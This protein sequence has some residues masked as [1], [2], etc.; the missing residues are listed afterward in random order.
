MAETCRFSNFSIDVLA[1]PVTNRPSRKR[2]ARTATPLYSRVSRV[3]SLKMRSLF[4]LKRRTEPSSVTDDSEPKAS[5]ETVY[6]RL[7][8][9]HR[10]TQQPLELSQIEFMP[11]E[12]T[13]RLELGTR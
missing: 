12:G 7:A 10:G 5:K 4:Y 3:L 9:R 6:L 2:H 11:N 8:F 13:L 1:W